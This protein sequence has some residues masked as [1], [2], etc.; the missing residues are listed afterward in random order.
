M[1]NLPITVGL[2]T[3]SYFFGHPVY[4]SY[5]KGNPADSLAYSSQLLKS[6]DH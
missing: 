4:F 6:V 1:K 2:N 5:I 3:I